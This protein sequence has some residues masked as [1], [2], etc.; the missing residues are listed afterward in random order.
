M[1]NPTNSRECLAATPETFI[2]QYNLN[3]TNNDSPK[4]YSKE[5]QMTTVASQTSP[6]KGI[7][8][9]NYVIAREQTPGNQTGNEPVPFLGC[10]S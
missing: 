3:N 4:Q 2:D 5:T 10:S 8:P 1:K 7:Q 9:Q 6:S